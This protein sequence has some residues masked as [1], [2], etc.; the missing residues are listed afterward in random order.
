MRF[1]S[2][3]LDLSI[4][5]KK[6]GDRGYPRKA[7]SKIQNVGNSTG[8]NI[9]LQQIARKKRKRYMYIPRNFRDILMC[10]ICSCIH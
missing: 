9:F 2:R 8:Q 10:N 7:V 6:T 1:L 5:W 4:L 3:L